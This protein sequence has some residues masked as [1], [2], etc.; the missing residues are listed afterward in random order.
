MVRIVYDLFSIN[1]KLILFA[2]ARASAQQ[3]SVTLH[4]SHGEIK[5]R[6][7]S[8]HQAEAFKLISLSP[9]ADRSILRNRTK[10]SRSAFHRSTTCSSSLNAHLTTLPS[11]TPAHLP[12]LLQNFLA[13]C[14]SGQYDGCLF[15]RCVFSPP[16]PS[17]PATPYNAST[18]PRANL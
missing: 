9:L 8:E 3:Q 11:L 4:T 5:V 10:D 14:A 1:T 17:S 6:Q 16:L 18:E 15:H 2:R 7:T 13:L 12:L